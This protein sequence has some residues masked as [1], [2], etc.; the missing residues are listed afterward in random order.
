MTI[1]RKATINPHTKLMRKPAKFALSHHDDHLPPE[2][3]AAQVKREAEFVDLLREPQL[4]E[5]T[6]RK[7]PAP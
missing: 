7:K 1:E 4:Y 2:R 6:N 5:L 3:A